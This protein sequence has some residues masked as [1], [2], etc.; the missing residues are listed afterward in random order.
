MQFGKIL[1]SSEELDSNSEDEE[2]EESSSDSYYEM[3]QT[4]YNNRLGLGLS[5][6]VYYVI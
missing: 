6:S 5:Y 4:G 1:D 3:H 2:E